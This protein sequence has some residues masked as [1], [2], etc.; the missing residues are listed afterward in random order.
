MILKFQI[1]IIGILSWF[2]QQSLAVSKVQLTDNR[3]RLYF[4]P[5]RLIEFETILIVKI[6]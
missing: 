3:S 6:G 1:I 4:S 2:Q 5:S